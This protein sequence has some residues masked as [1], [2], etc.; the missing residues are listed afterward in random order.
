MLQRKVLFIHIQ[1]KLVTTYNDEKK[2][3]LLERSIDTNIVTDLKVSYIFSGAT[4]PIR[5]NALP[6]TVRTESVKPNR[7]SLNSFGSALITGNA[8]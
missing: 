6:R 2:L 5:V 8:P 7:A 4:T 1:K 3:N